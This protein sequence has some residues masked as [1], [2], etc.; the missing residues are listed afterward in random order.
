MIVERE[1]ENIIIKVNPSLVGMAEIQRTID[2]FRLLESNA[3]NQGTKEQVDE[4]SRE[5]HQNWLKEN[6]H[7]IANL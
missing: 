2:F 7:R 4:L 5:S 6:Q 3:K 1:N